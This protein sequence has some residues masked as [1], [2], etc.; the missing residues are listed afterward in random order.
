MQ[1]GISSDQ[2]ASRASKVLEG[3][4]EDTGTGGTSK[5]KL[6]ALEVELLS[7]STSLGLKHGACHPGGAPAIALACFKSSSQPFEAMSRP[8]EL[9][10]HV[11]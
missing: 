5:R 1:L 4:S 3:A 11:K 10:I 9:Y 6:V 2:A 8:R 7:F